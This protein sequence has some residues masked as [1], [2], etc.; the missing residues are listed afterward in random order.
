MA[1]ESIDNLEPIP[2]PQ[3]IH[4]ASGQKRRIIIF[5]VVTLVNISLLI[6]LWTQLMTPRASTSQ[7]DTSVV[8]N[9]PTT[10]QGKSAPDFTLAILNGE[11]KQISLSSL[12]GKAVMLNFWSSSCIPCQQ[13]APFLQQT[14]TKLQSSAST[15]D[16]VLLGLDSSDPNIQDAQNFLSTYGITYPN[17][18]DNGTQTGFDYGI[19]GWPETFFIDKNGIVS[20]HW[21]G[22]LDETSVRSQLAKIGV[23]Y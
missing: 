11:S 16:V 18:R 15:K 14:W 7:D 23:Q 21:R 17:I 20:S 6:V 19:T 10:L 5:V 22:P 1:T 4:P 8:G 13:E 9:A 12:K 3:K 2:A